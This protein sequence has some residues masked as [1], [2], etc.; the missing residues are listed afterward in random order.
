[1]TILGHM[2]PWLA[3]LYVVPERRGKGIGTA[4]TIAIQ[5]MAGRIGCDALYLFTKERT[6]FYEGLGWILFS[7]E[8]YLDRQVGVMKRAVSR[9]NEVSSDRDPE[10]TMFE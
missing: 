10:P 1:M 9:G 3:S 4:L 5:Q 6:S 7:N 2:R 8:S